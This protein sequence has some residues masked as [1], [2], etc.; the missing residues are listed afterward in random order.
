MSIN[1][2]YVDG[3]PP[4]RGPRLTAAALGVELNLKKVDMGSG[5]H[6]KPEFLKMNPEHTIPTMD[7]NG[8]YLWESRAI[9]KYLAE[10]ST[11][12]YLSESL[13]PKCP[14]A[15]A[16]VHQRLDFDLGTL[17]H[18]FGQCF[19]PLMLKGTTEIPEEK[20]TALYN[21][22]SLLDGFISSS[23]GYV[24]GDHITIADH[25][26]AATV[27]SMAEAGVNISKYSHVKNWYQKIQVEMP[28]YAEVNQ[29][30]A[31]MFGQMV[32][33]KMAPHGITW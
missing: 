7:H 30:G 15:R 25:S 3:S 8:F 14:M 9:C 13:Y 11:Q 4:C 12:K 28:G 16:V 29:P 17:Y 2:Y 22:L 20:K 5:E 31:S 10:S 19:F 33:S 1:Y 6:R 24:A 21:A 26:V 23:G 18:K 27:S 32:K